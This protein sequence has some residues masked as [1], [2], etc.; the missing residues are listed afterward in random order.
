[1]IFNSVTFFLFY[2][3]VLACCLIIQHLPRIKEEKRSGLRNLLLLAASYYFY[4]F[5]KWEFLLLLVGT[6]LVNYI[7]AFKIQK[8][9]H[10]KVYLWIAVILSIGILGYFKYANFFADSVNQALTILGIAPRM[11]LT[12]IMLPIGISF[13]TFQALSYTFDVYFRKM[14][15]RKNLINVALYVSFFPSVL[16]GPIERGRN[17]IPQIET[18]TR[19]NPVELLEGGKLF[20]WGLFKKIVIADRLA[21]YINVVYAGEPESFSSL[22]LFVTALLYSVQIY[23]DFSGYS[24]MAIGIARSL[25]FRLMENFRFPYFSTSIKSFWKSW[26]I[27]LTSW[28]S[29]YVYIPLGGNRVTK[30]RWIFNIS[31]V[32]LLSGLWHGANWTFILWGALHAGYYITEHYYQ[33]LNPIRKKFRH[34]SIQ[35]IS[36]IISVCLVFVLVTIAWIFFRIENFDKACHIISRLFAGTSGLYMGSSAFST[37]LMLALLVLF[38]G[39]EW[40]KYKQIGLSR[41]GSAIVYAVVLSMVLLWGVT[42]GGFV[43]FQF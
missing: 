9:S 39:M 43:Y 3:V 17:L 14:Q 23:A 1:M 33:Q 11:E 41:M 35:A 27:S 42:S 22:T 20:L 29:E 2:S 37:L 12:Q 24:D 31:V 36:S 6:T 16:S 21:A 18:Y 13:F 28:F 8:E 38:I 32:F 7:C 34:R 4:A 25:G 40:V 26:H 10:R 30:P 19:L 15:A 5:L